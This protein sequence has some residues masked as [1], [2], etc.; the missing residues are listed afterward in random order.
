MRGA[1]GKVYLWSLIT[2][3]GWLVT[4]SWVPESWSEWACD[5]LDHIEWRLNHEAMRRAL[6]IK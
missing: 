4:W 5:M 1:R 6:G 2:V 3:C